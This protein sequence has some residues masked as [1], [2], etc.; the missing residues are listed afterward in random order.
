MTKTSSNSDPVL[1]RVPRITK[2][3]LFTFIVFSTVPFWIEGIGLFQYIGLEILIW[4]IYTMGYNLSLGYT[5]LPSFGLQIMPFYPLRSFS[6]LNEF[7]F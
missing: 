2:S 7:L 5:G 3:M 1:Y 6:K 4:C